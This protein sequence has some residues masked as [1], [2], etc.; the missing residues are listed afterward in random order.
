MRYNKQFTIEEEIIERLRE[1]VNA[2]QLVNELLMRHYEIKGKE[3]MSLDEREA[4]LKQKLAR[5][6]LE[7]KHK[8]E[9][10]ALK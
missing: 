1:E 8:K 7:E 10:E 4:Y 9:L 2:S 6:K 3:G 5:L